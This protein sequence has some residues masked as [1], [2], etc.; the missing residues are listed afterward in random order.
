MA[1]VYK[2]GMLA[3]MGTPGMKISQ[4]EVSGGTYVG[5]TI[6]AKDI[7]LSSI[8]SMTVNK[9]ALDAQIGTEYAVAIGTFL[10][11]VGD[12]NYAT[13]RAHVTGGTTPT[14]LGTMLVFAIG[15]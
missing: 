15:M 2:R 14:E 5:L 6:G 8:Y 12:A 11:G 9:K 4:Y 1:I 10:A 13:I 3:T 7:G